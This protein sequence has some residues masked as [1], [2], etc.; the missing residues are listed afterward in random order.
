[1]R[2]RS[3][4]LSALLVLPLPLMADTFSTYTLNDVTFAN[5]GA[6]TGTVTFDTTTGVYTGF[7]VTYTLGSFEELFNTVSFSEAATPLIYDLQSQA[8]SG[9]NFDFNLSGPQGLV[10]S[11]TDPCIVPQGND[12]GAFIPAKGNLIFMTTGSLELATPAPVPE[13]GSLALLGTG[14]LGGV[15]IIRRRMAI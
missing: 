11:T 7:D 6:A 3:L 8:A 10:C 13:P 9:D 15:G 2:L 5:G 1:M 12:A 14:L 4:L